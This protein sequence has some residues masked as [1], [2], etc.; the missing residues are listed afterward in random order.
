MEGKKLDIC[1]DDLIREFEKYR[2]D[3]A[4][5]ESIKDFEFRLMSRAI[6]GCKQIAKTL[7]K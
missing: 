5:K 6:Y 4:D 2:E 7:I 3:L 1:S